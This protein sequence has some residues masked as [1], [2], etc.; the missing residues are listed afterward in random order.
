VTTDCEHPLCAIIGGTCS[1][2]ARRSRGCRPNLSSKEVATEVL[3]E[4]RQLLAVIAPEARTEQVR[5]A[6]V[7][8]AAIVRREALDDRNLLTI[9]SS[10]EPDLAPALAQL[11]RRRTA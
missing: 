10:D 11:C 2:A 5:T 4:V 3:D 1:L 7:R 8:L 6:A 9:I